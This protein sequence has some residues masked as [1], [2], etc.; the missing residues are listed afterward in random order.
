MKLFL[1]FLDFFG[2]KTLINLSM[3][4]KEEASFLFFKWC[5][6]EVKIRHPL[7]VRPGRIGTAVQCQGDTLGGFFILSLNNSQTINVVIPA[8]PVLAKAGSG[9]PHQINNLVQVMDARLLGHDNIEIFCLNG[10]S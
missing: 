1:D 3:Y 10:N 9:N 4:P 2:R 8:K 6:C 7:R 5:V